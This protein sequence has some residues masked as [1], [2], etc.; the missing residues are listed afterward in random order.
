MKITFKAEQRS[1]TQRTQRVRPGYLVRLLGWAAFA[2]ATTFCEFAA[3]AQTPA[4]EEALDFLSL[5]SQGL[6]YYQGSYSL[7][8]RFTAKHDIKVTQLG[9][10]DDKQN[11]LTESHKVGIYD[12]ATKQ[13]LVSGTVDPS[14][15]LT[16]FFRYH[17]VTPVTLPGGRDYYAMAVNGHETYAIYPSP[18]VVNSAISF[19]D[20]VT[21]FTTSQATDL[22]YP[23]TEAKG[24]GDFGPG[25]MIENANPESAAVDMPS[26][27]GTDVNQ[28]P[29]SMG[30]LFRPTK[31][32]KVSSLGYYDDNGDGFKESH[33]VAI[34]DAL[35][36]QIV[37]N[38]LVTSNDPLRGYFR[39]HP[40]TAPPLQA[41]HD[42]F[43][44][45]GNTYDNYRRDVTTLSVDPAINLVGS[46]FNPNPPSLGV[47]FPSE[48]H[49]NDPPFFGPTFEIGGPS[50]PLNIS[51]RGNVKSG[52]SVMIGGFI[53][54]GSA[55]KKV[56]IRGIGPSLPVSG[57]LSDPTL[58]LFDSDNVSLAVNDNWKSS[59]QQEI[60]DTG[61]PPTSELESAIVQTLNPGKYTAVLKGNGNSGGT[62]LVEV[63]DISSG[64][65]S[66]L[67]NISTRGAVGSGAAL[68]DAHAE[69]VAADTADGPLIGGFIV[70]SASKYLI[71]A[72]GPSLAGSGVADALQDPTL[73][74]HDGN[75][76]VLATND[77]WQDTQAS[78]IQATGIPPN[79][80]REAAI[81]ASLQGG[82]YTAVVK[83][84]NGGSGVALVEVYDIQ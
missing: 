39:Y 14:D 5:G 62:G 3:N 48:S 28:A 42:Y 67:A 79:D 15:P 37:V 17:A 57:A 84:N 32:V 26:L 69:V 58:E 43:V 72:I 61:I 80:P 35:T 7:G 20:S 63:Y 9:F 50:Q 30:Y 24:N 40:V 29:F 77:N 23:D 46:A 27:T 44:M 10:Y 38:T 70:G 11:G 83:G 25:F 18:L 55:P 6:D 13:L 8:W 22:M 60:Q 76:A 33:N 2:G 75:G 45:G 16:G 64:S 73:E 53:V 68:H 47:D 31:D 82:P 54:T 81:V 52:N 59:Q 41:G 66:K 74:L 71:R 19:V 36:K 51:T 34:F 4:Q 21:N 56:L 78:E 49:P 1:I 12:V 65:N